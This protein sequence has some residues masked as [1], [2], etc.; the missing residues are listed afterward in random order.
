MSAVR[1]S[2]V[3]NPLSEDSPTKKSI[4]DKFVVDDKVETIECDIN[5]IINQRRA[6]ILSVITGWRRS[7]SGK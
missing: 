3:R 4:L 7:V 1:W 6:F 5:Q 2:D